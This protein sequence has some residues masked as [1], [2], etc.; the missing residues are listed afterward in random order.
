[1]AST[2]PLSLTPLFRVASLLKASKPSHGV[3]ELS[4]AC[5][6]H[7]VGSEANYGGQSNIFGERIVIAD[8]EDRVSCHAHKA[9]F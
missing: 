4:P 9:E 2:R 1:M 5:F 7:A 8:G 3:G 6:N